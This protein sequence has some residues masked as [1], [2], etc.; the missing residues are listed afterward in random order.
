MSSADPIN[1][2][3]EAARSTARA[4]Y[5]ILT[6]QARRPFVLEITG[7]PKAGKTTL[8]G[9]LDAFLRDC[10]FR[11]QVL[12]E[13]ASECPLPMKG[14]FFFNTW[15]TGT[16]LAG[17]IDA[18]D[19]EHDVVILDRGI[20][21]ALIWLRMQAQEGQTTKEESTAFKAFVKL[22]RW[23]RLIDRVCLIETQPETAMQ[24]ENQNRLIP[25]S[26][27][28]MNASRL[29]RFNDAMR[30]LA[31]EEADDFAPTTLPNQGNAKQGALCLIEDLLAA[32]RTW[33]DPEIAVV[34]REFVERVVPNGS[35]RWSGELQQEILA[36][37]E[38]RQ[39]S[40]IEADD[41]FVQVMA[42][43]AQTHDQEVFV[44]VRRPSRD[45]PPSSRDNTAQIWRG[46]HLARRGGRV[47]LIEDFRR[48][49]N[50]RLLGDL[51]LGDLPDL[52]DPLGIVWDPAG[53]EPRHLAVV[54]RAAV[55]DKLAEWL[56]EKN[57]K[58]NGRGYRLE[59]SFAAPAELSD[60]I[61]RKKDYR[62]EGWSKRILDAGWLL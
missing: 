28:V 5:P 25:R 18:I 33:C 56:D 39:R 61:V 14:H 37:L 27:S 48:Q 42:C 35:V 59:S 36:A 47:L 44:V 19:R 12:K 43:G 57:F 6:R 51:H 45:R 50:A 8:I 26:G 15:T 60:E 54:F 23:R 62:V 32:L 53:E 21:D 17:L 7:T 16:M 41:A 29:S 55:P 20:F 49:L 9:M 58:T 13:R 52:G 24:R 46:C 1:V 2:Q 30:E 4:L 10:G 3:I 34:P 40:T 22:E 31:K 38:Y 11:V